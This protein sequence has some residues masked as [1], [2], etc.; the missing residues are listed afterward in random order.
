M[1][2]ESSRFTQN[3]G[4][5]VIYVNGTQPKQASVSI[6]DCNVSNNPGPYNNLNTGLGGAIV[7]DSSTTLIDHCNIKGNRALVMM[8]LFL[9]GG[10]A[11]LV[12]GSSDVIAERYGN[13]GE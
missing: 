13:R 10:N 7:C 9:G 12:F 5:Y 11:G 1:Q 2:V 8:P 6:R 4:S 3:P